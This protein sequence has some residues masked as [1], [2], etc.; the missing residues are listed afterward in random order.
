M[1]DL[2]QPLELL[3]PD[4]ALKAH[5]DHL[6]GT[7][8][9][10]LAD[11]VTGAV[12]FA[13]NKLMKFHGI[14]QQDDRDIREERRLQ[15]LEPAY[16][17][18]IRVRL[19]GGICTP[20]QWLAI[21][22]LARQHG[23][24]SIR[25]TSRQT[26]QFHWVVKED[27]RAVIQG[28]D[29]ALLDTIAAC[30]DDARGVMCTVAPDA[31]PLEAELAALSKSLSDHVIPRMPAYREIWLGKERVD[32]GDPEEPFYGTQYLPRK[33]K[34]GI[35]LPPSNDIDVFTQDL[36]F[37]AIVEDGAITGFNITVGG[38]LGRSD[39]DKDT[40]ARL[41]DVL[42]FVPKARLN[43]AA[44]AVMGVQRDFGNRAVRARARFKY[45]VHDRG[46]D[47]IRA[48]VEKRLGVPLEPARPF[49]F[50]SNADA[51]GWARRGDGTFDV[52]IPILA[53]RVTGTLADT[54]RTIAEGHSGLFR[55]TP[56]QN[57]IVAGVTEAQRAT[58][59]AL[60]AEHNEAAA[61]TQA[62]H[63]LP[64]VALPTCPLA[65]AEA[66]R[67]MPAFLDHVRAIADRHGVGNQPIT[68][69][70]SGCPNGCS[71]PYVAEIALTGRAPGRYNLYLGG[72]PRGD[73]LATLVAANIDEQAILAQ[74]DTEFAA[75]AAQH[76]QGESFGDFV[77]RAN[78]VAGEA[79]AASAP[80][81]Q[82]A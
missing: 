46:I 54:I 34:I 21:D 20:Q 48:E 19:P 18:M 22:S 11:P 39:Q 57:L 79:D 53:G 49:A 38:G 65:M 55:L 67:Y 41:G 32:S 30:G 75:Y 58:V 52:T 47:F 66:E 72:S 10:T 68:V 35:A 15:K 73:R 51:Q 7:I 44:M 8:L 82:E 24:G 37:I 31:G 77:V 80:A 61:A 70:I 40:F 14:Y 43:D 76:M 23:D 62:L 2:S 33:F 29:A 36:G 27:V 26:F 81:R 59:E 69:R 4:E 64:C 6:R 56:N 78:L 42:G 3:G 63:A 16:S 74:L 13:D 60:L 25:L 9:Q 12:T 1:T 5:S 17:F 50:D 71:R 28:L 45:T